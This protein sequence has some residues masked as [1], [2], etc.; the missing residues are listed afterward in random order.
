ME[1]RDTGTLLA[2]R[3]HGESAAIVEVFTEGRG[4]TSGLVRG[5]AGR[6]LA[7]V[8]QPGAVLDVVWRARLEEHL[9]T[10]SVEPVRARVSI[11]A[12]ALALAGLHAVTALLVHVLA[13]RDPHPRLYRMTEALLDAM[14]AGADWPADYARWELALLEEAGFG[15]DLT[16]C[17]VTGTEADLVFVSPRTGRAVSRDA[18]GKW[19]DRLLPL[20]PVLKGAPGR[21]GDVLAALETTGHF[22][23]TMVAPA[24]GDRPLPPARQRLV[25][26]LSRKR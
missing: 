18:A 23:D 5:G 19:A 12:D 24:L 14:D 20:S 26:R 9:G 8:L 4:R 22:L 2:V 11:L 15:L 13:E 16:R 10:F 21:R 25:D 7:P 3:G 17:A 6:R 1:W